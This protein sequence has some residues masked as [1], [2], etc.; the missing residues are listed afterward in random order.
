MLIEKM[1]KRRERG[2]Q[3]KI[4][5]GCE[6]EGNRVTI[7]KMDQKRKKDMNI[8]TENK[9]TTRKVGIEKRRE[10][11]RTGKRER[12]NGEIDQR[13]KGIPRTRR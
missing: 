9:R 4:R 10:K 12:K 6:M 7:K 13:R 2:K 1:R 11:R 8:K 5:L 3:E